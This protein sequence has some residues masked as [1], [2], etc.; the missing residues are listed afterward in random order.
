MIH[1]AVLFG[2][3][4][5]G[6]WVFGFI[7]MMILG[8]MHEKRKK[9]I[10]AKHKFDEIFW[11]KSLTFWAFNFDE[12]ILIVG[13]RDQALECAFDKV[14]AIEVIENGASLTKTTRDSPLLRA[15][16][17][18]L[19]F[20]GVGAIVGGLSASS[21]SQSEARITS[22]DLKLIIDD[23]AHPTH[24][25]Q[26]LASAQ[27]GHAPNSLA[28]KNARSVADRMHGHIVNAMRQALTASPTLAASANVDADELR[29]FWDLKQAG[30]ISEGEFEHQK[31]RILS[32]SDTVPDTSKI[33]QLTSPAVPTVPVRSAR[34]FYDRLLE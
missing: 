15:A 4:V 3:A 24:R 2:E 21:T 33:A 9:A 26:V 12:R 22:I 1:V 7:A 25:F 19:L 28:V 8:P 5:A 32:V 20:G 6:L 11:G 14:A 13:S 34:S 16:V 10:A 23:R 18:G 29:K 30:I 31:R 27:S 17:G